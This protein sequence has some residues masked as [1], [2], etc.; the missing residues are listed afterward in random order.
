M[1][2]SIASLCSDDAE[3][4]F[5]SIWCMVLLTAER[6]IVVS[7]PLK[8]VKLCTVRRAKVSVIVTVICA[9]LYNL[10]RAFEVSRQKST[11]C[12]FPSKYAIILNVATLQIRVCTL[13]I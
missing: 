10:P 6:Y 5:F 2:N 7:R 12:K 13:Y 8:S 3:L 1:L 9:L 11:M 4:L